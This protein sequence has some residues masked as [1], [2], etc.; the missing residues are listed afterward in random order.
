MDVT[1][2]LSFCSVRSLIAD[3]LGQLGARDELIAIWQRNVSAL[4]FGVLFSDGVAARAGSGFDGIGHARSP[5]V[6]FHR[7][8][9]GSNVAPEFARH[10]L[11]TIYREQCLGRP[12]YRPLSLI[13]SATDLPAFSISAPMRSTAARCGSSNRCA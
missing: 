6:C 8:Y 4:V 10:G 2:T 13:G 11:A 9:E 5:M 1:G 7:K 3:Q 12:R